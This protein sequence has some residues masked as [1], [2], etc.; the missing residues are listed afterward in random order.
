MYNYKLIATDMD[1]TL[2]NKEHEIS[3]K[4]KKSIIDIQEKGVKFVLA[5]GRPTFAMLDF[6]EDLEM[7]KYGGYILGFNGGEIIDIADG[8]TIFEQALSYEDIKIIYNEAVIRNLS[9]LFYTE[10]TI[11]ANELNIY[12]GEEIELTKMNYKE[13]VDIDLIDIESTIKCMILGNPSEL[14]IAQK[15]ISAK[16]IDKYVVNISKPIFME[17]TLKGINKGLSLKRLCQTIGIAPNDIICVGD[18]YNDLSMLEMAGLPIAVENAR[19]ELKNISKF[20]TT[21]N[22]NHAL[23]TLIDEFF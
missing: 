11:Y 1:D 4:N 19:E 5:S 8:T 14:A 15:E 9:F 22:N 23:K 2:L 13:I 7:K 18:S 21:S 16:Y 3:D 12:T 6:A 10:D 20:I 17:F